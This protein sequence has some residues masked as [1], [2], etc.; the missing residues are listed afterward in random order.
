M[1]R[2]RIFDIMYSL[3][4]DG[5]CESALF[6][7]CA[8]AAR[9]ALFRSLTGNAFPELW[10]E[11]PLL[12]IPWF[13]FHALVSYKDV[14]GT[15]AKFAGQSGIYNDALAWFAAQKPKTVRQLALSYDTH[16]ND[17]DHPAVQLLVDRRN[18]TVPKAFLQSAGQPEAK[19]SYRVFVGA[20]PQQWYPCYVG[21][22]P[23]R[24]VDE[25]D[26]WTRVE[27]IVGDEYQRAYAD[28]DALLRKHLACVGIKDI[29]PDAIAYI[30]ELARSPFPLEFQFN[31]GQSGIA[32]PVISASVRFQPGDWKDAARQDAI[33][34]LAKWMMAHN[35]ADDRCAMLEKT[36][37]A[38]RLKYEDDE[39]SIAC[40]PAFVKLR[41]RK[42]QAPDAKAYL[43]AFAG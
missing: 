30:Q 24:T 6:G 17:V 11:L 7:D 1:D 43:I 19:D 40:F 20:M 37:F 41:F 42:E 33:W 21:I 29:N 4:A 9:E 18:D 26:A 2:M 27:C 14:A 5:G 13:D 28:D 36:L 31:V 12:G 10:F 32:L 8:P 16:T 25:M 39:I 15:Q 34:H 38:K 23:G 22:F 3:A 35:L